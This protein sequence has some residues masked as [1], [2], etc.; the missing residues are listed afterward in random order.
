MK[1]DRLKP[2]AIRAARLAADLTQAD[3]AIKMRE[4]D[5]DLRTDGT[6]ISRYEAGRRAPDRHTTRALMTV[7]PD[8]DHS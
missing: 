3:L 7:L 5:P 4:V 1:T 6:M 8:L 2:K